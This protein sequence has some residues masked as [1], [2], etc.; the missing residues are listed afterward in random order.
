MTPP[1][2]FVTVTAMK[3]TKFILI[4]AGVLGL[5]ATFA[6]P[7]VSAGPISLKFWDFSKMPEG[8]TR[9]L[10]NGP[11]QVYVALVGFL[12][13]AGAGAAGMKRMVRW[14]GILAVVGGL[15]CFATEG[16]RKGLTGEGGVSTA[17][18]GKL[19]FVAA[20]LGIVG[21]VLAIAKPEN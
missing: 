11:K 2:R 10:L 8:L 17:I 21:G 18:G 13:M 16:V 6:L 5:L 3:Q 15:L 20:L 19:L 4:A 7:Y 12:M 14:Q 9:G 1:R